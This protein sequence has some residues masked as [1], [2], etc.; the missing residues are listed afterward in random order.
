M[1]CC[2]ATFLGVLYFS[3]FILISRY[4]ILNVVV[5]MLV[6]G[7][8]KSAKEEGVVRVTMEQEIEK[9]FTVS[10]KWA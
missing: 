7:F 1:N 6:G 9:Q 3:L 10:S 4:V 5:A 2:L 8:E